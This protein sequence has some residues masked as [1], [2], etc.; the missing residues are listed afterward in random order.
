MS[1]NL[2]V[3]IPTRNRASLLRN[4][5]SS[6]L[7]QN[8]PKEQFEVIV[9]DNGS[10]DNTK[11][12][13]DTFLHEFNNFRYEYAPQPGLHVGRNI[14]LRVAKAEIL[15]Y[16]DDDIE[17]F[18]T[19]LQAIWDSFQESDSVGIV[20]GKNIPKWE[21]DPP[22]WI[23]D[24]W[25]PDKD[26]NRIM[27]SYSIID[28]GEYIKEINP[29]YV[30]GCNF[31]IRRKIIEHTEGF[32]PDGM[33]Q[34]LI[35]FR[36]DGETYVSEYVSANGYKAIYNPDASVFHFV[37]KNR[38]TLEY[39]KIRSF[40]QG[41]SQSYTDFR[42]KYSDIPKFNRIKFLFK[43]LIRINKTRLLNNENSLSKILL[44]AFRDGY[45]YH[46]KSLA[47]NSKLRKWVLQKN[48]LNET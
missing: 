33:P 21:I 40:N 47:M 38:L 27:G 30:W 17:A 1:I 6:I 26:N 19:W 28:L 25:N 10:T 23:E 44:T 3:I 22:N 45:N 4:T 43:E 24:M 41:I 9:V 42:K 18:P 7:I 32:H 16:I 48:Y 8:F 34:N 11:K 39:L 15:V 5:L 2:S 37:S 29:N 31:S 20:G 13:C 46:R 14:G 12:I 36:G 35:M